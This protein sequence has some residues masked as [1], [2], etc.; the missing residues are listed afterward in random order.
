LLGQ[1]I[2]TL[3][4]GLVPSGAHTVNWDGRNE[5]G[6]PVAKGIYFYRLE[7]GDV[8]MT[9]KLLLIKESLGDKN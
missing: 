3:V 8:V 5:N 1:E 2:R 7:A 9:K 4:D 6:Q